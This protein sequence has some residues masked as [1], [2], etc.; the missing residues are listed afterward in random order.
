MVVDGA[1]V[2]RADQ[3]RYVLLYKPPGCVTTL[4]DPQGRPTAR[5]YLSGV[6]E[7]VFPVGRLDY[8]AEG[9]LLFTD[10][11]ELA[12]RLAHPSYRPPAR[13][14]GEDQGR[15]RIERRCGGSSRG[16]GWRTARPGR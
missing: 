8:D 13:L 15:C 2:E 5:G 6:E 7:R 16:S 9:A 4:S 12:N 11:G 3:R 1:P 14:P 10:D